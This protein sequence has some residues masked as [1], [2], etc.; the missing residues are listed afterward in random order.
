MNRERKFYIAIMVV[1]IAY[2]ITSF[3]LPLDSF[4]KRIT[5]ITALI[6]AVAFWLQFKRAERLNESNYISNFPH[7]VR[8]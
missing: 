6:S 4:S 3:F 8:G 1:V 7:G 5:T 2:L